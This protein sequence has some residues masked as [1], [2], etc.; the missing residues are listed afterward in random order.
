[1]S[2]IKLIIARHGNT[3]NK[4]DIILRV[5]SRTDLPLTEEGKKQGKKLGENL[6]SANITPSFYYSAPLKRTIET[7][8]EVAK[9]FG[10][11][12]LPTIVDFLTELDYGE[13]DGQPEQ[14]V[15]ERLGS[16]EAQTHGFINLPK[17][18]LIEL[19]KDCL[20]RWDK[21]M[22]LPQG[23][24]F[25]QQRVDSL[26]NDWRRFATQ[27]T[28]KTESSTNL[29]VTSNGIARF[30]LSILPPNT[31]LPESLKISTGAFCLFSWD[32]KVWNLDAW[33]VQ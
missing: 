5:G 27:L 14:L 32:G 23:W 3:F 6:R 29:V 15:I 19:G 2:Q 8:V 11:Q 1:M 21:K 7:T 33:N 10:N 16:I 13:F 24:K 4:G 26:K 30:A 9:V 28:N 17:D 25:L 20:T 31:Q 18:S 22:I 12:S